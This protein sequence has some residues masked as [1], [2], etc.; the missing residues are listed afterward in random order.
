LTFSKNLDTCFTH[1][2][3]VFAS[4]KVLTKLL[5]KVRNGAGLPEETLRGEQRKGSGFGA[6]GGAF[7]LAVNNA[8]PSA[9]GRDPLQGS[10]ESPWS[11]AEFW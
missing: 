11:I 10:T 3:L 1:S 5:F 7:F 6:C 9:R 4:Y 2:L 8:S